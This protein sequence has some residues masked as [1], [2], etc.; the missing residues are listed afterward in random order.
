LSR[1]YFIRDAQGQ[2]RVGEL[3]L[4]LRIGGPHQGGIVV[5]GVGADELFA[6]IALADGHAYIQ[7]AS[8]DGALFLNDERLKDSAWLKSGDRMQI[9]DALLSWQVQGDKVLI[10]VLDKSE[11][12]VPQPPLQAPPGRQ[13]KHSDGLP[14]HAE[15]SVPHGDGR[16]WRRIIA[17]LIGLLLLAVF[18]LLAATP[19][20]VKVNPE[21]AHLVMDG[22]P[23]P[24]HLWGSRLVL[25]GRY[26]VQASLPGYVALNE[27]VDISMGGTTTLEY[28]LLEQPGLLKVS[29]RPEVATQV[30]IDDVAVS[31]DGDGSIPAPRGQHRLRVTTQRY[32]DHEQEIDIQGFG[33]RQQL[34]IT[35]QPAWAPVSITSRPAAAEVSI[36]GQ[37]VGQTPLVTDVLQGRHQVELK[38]AGF[39]PVILFPEIVAGRET[40]LDPVELQPVDGMLAVSTVPDGASVTVDGVFGGT[41][42]L[43]LKLAA[44]KAHRLQFSKAGYGTVERDVTL[45][46]DEQ[47]SIEIRLNAEY[48]TVFLTTRPAGARL[49]IDG[50]AV[51]QSSGR[52]RLTTRPHALTVSKPGYVS[53]IVSITPRK[54]VS[55]KLDIALQRAGQQVPTKN[56]AA[57]PAIVTTVAGQT[58]RLVQPPEPFKMGASRREAGRRA[59]ESRRLVRLKRPFYLATHEVTNGQFRSFQPTHDS[60]HFDGAALNGDDQPAV[61]ISW[62]DAARYCN[63]LSKQQGLPAAYAEHNGH[64]QAVSPMTTGYRLPTEAEWAWVARR[65]GQAS[66]QRYPWDGSYPPTGLHGN[67]ADARIADTLADVV[68]GYDDGYRGTAPVGSFAARPTGFY[69]LGGNVAEWMHDF[70]ATYPGEAQRLVIDPA[71]PASGEHHVVRGSSWRHGNITELRLSYRD[72]SSKP[73][74][75]LG[76][77]IARY[78]E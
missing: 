55:Q 9:A 70:Y 63:W 17:V 60:G 56:V 75:D 23:P 36:D 41:A 22:F 33:A 25:P 11:V 31:P 2:R 64:L 15:D 54:G 40:A 24:L 47:A 68:P 57:S 28:T 7:P 74:Y 5:P 32:L 78:A 4:P 18:Y 27:E 59:N 37:A 3:E 1:D 73:R 69:D 44:D 19:V 50:Q 20:A 66:E 38:Q 34:D 51:D 43:S 61:N 67:Y 16:R 48:G 49:A 39:K 21:P 45:A 8:D 72:Y 12:H 52:L 77:R 58:L 26:R 62:D 42:P 29:T 71:G 76:F 65:L 6:F 35:L 46:P 53:Q 14:V 30:Y 13:Q 10:H